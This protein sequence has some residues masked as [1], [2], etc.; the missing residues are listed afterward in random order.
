MW[1]SLVISPSLYTLA[2][3]AER[4]DNEPFEESDE[5]SEAGFWPNYAAVPVEF[6]SLVEE[7]PFAKYT[8]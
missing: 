8:L 6:H 2:A 3:M 7:G 4:D 5:S 1:I